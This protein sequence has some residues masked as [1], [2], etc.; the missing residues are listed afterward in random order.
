MRSL[1]PMP[2]GSAQRLAQLLKE[3]DDL[4]AYKRILVV[5]LRAKYGYP[6]RTIANMTGY[7]QTTVKTIQSQYLKQ[8]ESA[9]F[10]KKKGGRYRENLSLEQ[11]KEF[12][13]PYLE[14]AK[15]GQ[16]LEIGAIHQA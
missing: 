13:I 8:G 11:E 15:A 16:I 2:T 7:H 3:T 9:L 12:L 5:Y 10:P 6:S 4:K 14:K 1:T